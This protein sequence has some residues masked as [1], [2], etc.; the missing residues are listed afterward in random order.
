CWCRSHRC[1]S[2][3]CRFPW[4][5]SQLCQS[6][7][8]RSLWCQSQLCQYP[9]SIFAVFWSELV[10]NGKLVKCPFFSFKVSLFSLKKHSLIRY[11]LYEEWSSWKSAKIEI[12]GASL[13]NANLGAVSLSNAN[14]SNAVLANV[15]NATPEQLAQAKSLEPA[16]MPD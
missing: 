3:R 1:H 2:L 7:P 10:E 14:L 16:A 4:C 9:C 13:S 15:S 5:Q 11:H 8:C 6:L 12:R